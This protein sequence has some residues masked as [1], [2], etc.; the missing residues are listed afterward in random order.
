M[1]TIETDRYKNDFLPFLTAFMA[2]GEII[3]DEIHFFQ[4]G[5]MHYILSFGQSAQFL[6]TTW[7]F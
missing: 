6:H 3:N 4:V 7:C 1:P 5:K 2:D